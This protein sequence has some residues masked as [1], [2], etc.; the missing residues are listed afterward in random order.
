MKYKINFEIDFKHNSFPGKLIAFEGIDASGKSTQVKKLSEFL[1]QKG[2]EVFLTKNPTREHEIG[3]LIHKILQKEIKVPPVAIQY[4]YSADRAVQEIYVTE[5]LKKGETVI[6]DRY[7]WSTIPYGLADLKDASIE[8][9]AK[10][11]LVADSLLSHYHGFILPNYTF[12][13]EVS[14]ETALQRLNKMDKFKEIY[15]EKASIE[16]V[17]AGY[18]FLVE[19][20]KDEIIVINGEQPE[21]KVTEEIISHLSS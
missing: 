11:R 4:L 13:L 12:Y 17:K 9:T 5:R 19:K 3:T 16:R 7:F 18:D 21:E 8:D 6:T 1:K 15:E 20:F 10:I 2:E 14:V